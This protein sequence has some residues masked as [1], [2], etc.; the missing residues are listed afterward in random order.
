MKNWTWNICQWLG[1]RWFSI[2]AASLVP[3]KPRIV[4]NS[5]FPFFV[6][7]SPSLRKFLEFTV[8]CGISY[9][10]IQYILFVLCEHFCDDSIFAFLFAFSSLSFSTKMKLSFDLVHC[11]LT[12]Q[13]S[14]VRCRDNARLLKMNVMETICKRCF[15]QWYFFHSLFLYFFL[16][17]RKRWTHSNAH[18]S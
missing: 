10:S 7:G 8:I 12:S 13:K 2:I 15:S 18:R 16:Q 5:F 3:F 6:I 14:V 1:W 17:I 4:N 11:I 9:A